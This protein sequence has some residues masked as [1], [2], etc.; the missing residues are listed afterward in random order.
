MSNDNFGY[1]Q[2][3][4]ILDFDD[5][6]DFVELKWKTI[7]RDHYIRWQRKQ[8]ERKTKLELKWSDK[9]AIPTRKSNFGAGP[10]CTM[11]GQVKQSHPGFPPSKRTTDAKQKINSIMSPPASYPAS[12]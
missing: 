2:T 5:H 7:I 11:V 9:G 8:Q 6:C 10:K 1:F 4:L 3:I 12:T